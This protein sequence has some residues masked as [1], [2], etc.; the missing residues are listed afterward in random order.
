MRRTTFTVLAL[1]AVGGC[2]SMSRDPFDSDP[3]FPQM[4]AA[5]PTTPEWRRQDGQ[6][7]ASQRQ[8]VV[9]VA[10][11][12]PSRSSTENATTPAAPASDLS[13]LLYSS[14]P[15]CKR[16]AEG[17][18]EQTSTAAPSTTTVAAGCPT[19]LRLVNSR[20]ISFNY[21]VRDG[22]P[23]AGVA[24][25]CTQDM[26]SWKKCEPTKQTATACIVSVKDDGLYGFVL[27]ARTD[28]P[29]DRPEPGEMPQAWVAVDTMRPVVK[30]LGTEMD[31]S[32]RKPTLV[33]RWSA[34][35]K[36]FGPRPMTLSYAEKAAGP[37][38]TLAAN[39]ENSGHYEWRLPAQVPLG[40]YLRIQATDLMGN[41]GLAQTA[42]KLL[43][44]QVQTA[45]AE[46]PVEQAK[47]GLREPA[48]PA[49]PQP[50][51]FPSIAAI[52][53]PRPAPPRRPQV[54]ILSVEPEKD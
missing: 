23:G 38:T 18:E 15:P 50:V 32:A 52:D 24:V 53:L 10:A 35:D 45:S 54:S 28:E 41:V 14:S 49:Q 33:L 20:R 39:V 2:F 46:L 43:L 42:H 29:Q 30:M 27:R 31:E 13:R 5:K 9:S 22:A 12:L 34:Q 19:Q 36:N 25:W 37:W 44:P 3:P 48:V 47:P 6:A 21:Q 17:A 4:G 16:P 1:M 11:R 51:L 7:E 26:K 8:P 40:I